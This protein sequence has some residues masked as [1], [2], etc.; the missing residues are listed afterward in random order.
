MTE[1]YKIKCLAGF[2]VSGE[3]VYDEAETAQ[4][5]HFDPHE[6]EKYSDAWSI[7]ETLTGQFLKMRKLIK[8]E[9]D[10]LGVS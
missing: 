4:G 6:N 5:S 9:R 8:A 2:M 1:A 10:T 7:L 3:R